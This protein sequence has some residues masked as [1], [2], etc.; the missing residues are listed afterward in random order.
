[1]NIN[2]HRTK[3][4]GQSL[5]DYLRGQLADD[6]GV[7]PTAIGLDDNL[8]EDLGLDSVDRLVLVSRIEDRFGI[9]FPDEVLSELTTVRQFLLAL[10]G[11]HKD[12]A[13]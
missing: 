10:Q 4:Q 1:M 7:H 6:C 3:L 5:E 8:E 11:A 9:L 12:L 13:A 2:L